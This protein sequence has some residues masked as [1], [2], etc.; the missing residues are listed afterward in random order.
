MFVPAKE[1]KKSKI[2]PVHFIFKKC[3]MKELRKSLGN[4][5]IER[6]NHQSLKC[7]VLFT[8]FFMDKLMNNVL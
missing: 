2:L 1:F 8:K 7:D 4:S 6:R 3:T 5:K